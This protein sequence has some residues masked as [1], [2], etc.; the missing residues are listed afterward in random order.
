VIGKLNQGEISFAITAC[1]C[2]ARIAANLKQLKR[3]ATI[4]KR[5]GMTTIDAPNAVCLD[6]LFVTCAYRWAGEA[7]LDPQNV[8]VIDY[9]RVKGGDRSRAS[10][11]RPSPSP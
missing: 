1:P 5:L 6:N 7:T 4:S 10:G 2:T 11:S 8:V 9:R 3:Y